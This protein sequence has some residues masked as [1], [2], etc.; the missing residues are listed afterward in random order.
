MVNA[1]NGVVGKLPKSA[2]SHEEQIE[3]KV[4]FHMH[5][6][7]FYYF[8]NWIWRG[9]L[10]ASS[11]SHISSSRLVAT[12]V[13]WMANCYK[14]E[15]PDARISSADSSMCFVLKQDMNIWRRMMLW[16]VLLQLF[17]ILLLL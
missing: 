9:F 17:F 4:T 11:S 5:F 3:P 15:I 7:F 10:P 6:F 14:Q 8:V 2:Y 1:K 13:F 12:V 16:H